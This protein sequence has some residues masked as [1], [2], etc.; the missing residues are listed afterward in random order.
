M[1]NNCI[2]I[3]SNDL[4]KSLPDV[5]YNSVENNFFVFWAAA[6][7]EESQTA[8]YFISGQKISSFG[9]VL[10]EPVEVLKTENIVLLPRVLYNPKKNQYLVIYCLGGNNMNIRGVIL[11]ADG[12][13]VGEH[14]K[15]TDVPANQFHYTMAF[16]SKKNQFF[17]TYNDSRN[18]AGD[19]FGVILDDTG[20]VVKEEFVISNAVGHQVNP[21][22]CYNPQDDTY[23]VNWED[24]RAHGDSLTEYETLDVMT[25]IYGALLAADGTILVNNITMC[26]DANGIDGDQRFND[27]AYNSKTNQFLVSWTDTRDSLQNIGIV[28]RIV[29]ADGTMPAE[30][31]TLVDAPGAQMIGHTLY[32]LQD[33]KYFIAFERDLNDIDEFYFKDITAHLDIAAMW[34]DPNGQSETNMIDIFNGDGNQRF[35]RFAHNTERNTFL[36]VWQDDFPGVSDSVEGHI[37]SA[38]GNIMGKIYKK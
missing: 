23:L 30:D 32:L 24:F 28:G 29:E 33:D 13:A 31:F 5:A 35:V 11:D 8:D 26:V 4:K 3:S 9:K 6:P 20:A 17:I 1:K 22:V 19:V 36:M 38:G 27:I 2:E 15:V 10:G 14:F 34:L 25:D 7:G 37:M 21:V 12:K 18:G 16:N